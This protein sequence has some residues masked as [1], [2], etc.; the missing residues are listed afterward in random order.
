L[1]DKSTTHK[2]GEASRPASA[3]KPNEKQLTQKDNSVKSQKPQ[4]TNQFKSQLNSQLPQAQH[5]QYQ[6][7]R[8]TSPSKTH[9][10]QQ[11]Q[12]NQSKPASANSAR[13][14]PSSGNQNAQKQRS[15]RHQR[16]QSI[17][18]AIEDSEHK[19]LR[20]EHR[21]STRLCTKNRHYDVYIG[22]LFR[23][24]PHI[25]NNNGYELL[26]ETTFS[27]LFDRRSSHVQQKQS[28]SR[29][30]SA[31]E[32]KAQQ[33]QQQKNLSRQASATENNNQH[34]QAQ[35]NKAMPTV[36]MTVDGFVLTEQ[37]KQVK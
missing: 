27:R 19:R 32:N 26:E 2:H 36:G 21:L 15:S 13:H 6:N 28:L 25:L 20:E 23:D 14:K 5:K 34:Q 16:I 18:A 31:T 8:P 37:P 29:Q 22:H 12:K 35:T 4:S 11:Q 3:S 17:T 10:I 24:Q 33:A 9:Q 30:A 1:I 7:S